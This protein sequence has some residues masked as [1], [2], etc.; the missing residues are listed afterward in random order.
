MT[1]ILAG[2]GA[3]PLILALRSL[4]SQAT[5]QVTLAGLTEAERNRETAFY[6][7]TREGGGSRSCRIPSLDS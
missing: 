6:G 5:L 2:D 1:S 4:F 3:G 7:E